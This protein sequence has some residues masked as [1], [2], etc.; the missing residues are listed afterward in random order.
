MNDIPFL[1]LIPEKYRSWALLFVATVAWGGPYLTRIYH[2]LA[3]HGGLR[4]AWN[5][6]W[7]GTNIP[8]A[9]TATINTTAAAVDK[10]NQDGAN[11]LAAPVGTTND[12]TKP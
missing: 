1:N 10:I 5:A 6:V 3:T 12:P 2:A 7:F 11:P 4:G 9:M 8:P